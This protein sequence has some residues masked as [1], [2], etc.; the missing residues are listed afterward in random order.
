MKNHLLELFE[1]C[2]SKNY[3]EV[4]NGGSF[5]YDLRGDA[6][7]L[8]FEHSNGAVDWLNNLDFAVAPYRDMSPPWKCHAGFLRVWKSIQPYLLPL[9]DSPA[10][11][12]VCTVGYSHGAAIATL[13]HEFIW[14]RRLDLRQSICGYGY[15]APRVL[16]GCVPPAVAMRWSSY[17]L[18]RNQGDLVTRLPPRMSG[19]CH[20]GIP[21]EI[22]APNRY[23]AV[24]AHRPE[25]YLQELRAL[26]DKLDR[27]NIKGEDF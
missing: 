3:T 10:V 21:I 4:E 12:R 24:D 6:L 8:W 26:G 17:F 1:E 7:Y 15:G 27:S 5:A 16:Y 23:S 18:V 2:L 11:S 25:N 19:Y 9:I 13:C 22:G 14:F 20:A